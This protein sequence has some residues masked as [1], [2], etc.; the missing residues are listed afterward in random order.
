MDANVNPNGL[1][2]FYGPRKPCICSMLKKIVMWR[3]VQKGLL[4]TSRWKTRVN[5]LYYSTWQEKNMWYRC[6]KNVFERIAN[7]KSVL[8]DVYLMTYNLH[9]ILKQ[10]YGNLFENFRQIF[11]DME[12][13]VFFLIFSLFFWIRSFIFLSYCQ[14]FLISLNEKNWLKKKK[15]YFFPIYKTR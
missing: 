5:I 10:F 11:V 15:K 6:R 3:N 13:K 12:N 7:F 1:M 8:N 2:L 14:Q 4:M 9:S